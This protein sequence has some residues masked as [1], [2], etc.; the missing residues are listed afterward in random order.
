MEQAGA[1]T[2]L[3]CRRHGKAS[4]CFVLGFCGVGSRAYA[5]G[6]YLDGVVAGLSRAAGQ[7]G[8][9]EVFEVVAV[10]CP[11]WN[12][13]VGITGGAGR[14]AKMEGFLRGRAKFRVD[15]VGF[16][17]VGGGSSLEG[18][19]LRFLVVV[20]V[21]E[22]LFVRSKRIARGNDFAS[23]HSRP[24]RWVHTSYSSVNVDVDV[25][26]IDDFPVGPLDQHAK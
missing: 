20:E 7:V 13:L 24:R 21:D 3:G 9:A 8:G 19:V 23:R 18:V 22:I 4:W 5:A 26:F 10:N 6:F 16:D 12:A 17:G 15:A 25:G 11:F 14:A 1:D 2:A